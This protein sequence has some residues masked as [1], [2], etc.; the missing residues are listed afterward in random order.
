MK[1]SEVMKKQKII[2]ETTMLW[3]SVGLSFIS[4][5]IAVMALLVRLM[6]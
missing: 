4:L 6:K 2:K 1:G 3:L 5:L